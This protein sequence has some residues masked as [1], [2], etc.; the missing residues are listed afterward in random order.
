MQE[1]L[2]KDG[3]KLFYEK[4][5]E[6]SVIGQYV[7]YRVFDENNVLLG[8]RIGVRDLK[9]FNYD[10]LFDNGTLK[11]DMREEYKARKPVK[12]EKQKKV[13]EPSKP[14]MKA[15]DIILRPESTTIAS[16]VKEVVEP[17]EK[18]GKKSK[19]KE[20]DRAWYDQQAN[21][22]IESLVTLRVHITGKRKVTV[23]DILNLI[24]TKWEVTGYDIKQEKKQT[25]L[26]GENIPE[27]TGE[28][29]E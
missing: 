14:L 24:K 20:V 21:G 9:E 1:G 4:N 27:S 19:K 15:L 6:K 25:Q 3:K 8:N 29:N 7:M 11:P 28:E 10:E 2:T 26:V 16:E 22:Y 23:E 5:E 17:E 18:E 13:V 12:E